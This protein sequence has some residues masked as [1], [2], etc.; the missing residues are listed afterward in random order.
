MFVPTCGASGF[1]Y[2]VFN[3]WEMEQFLVECHQLYLFSGFMLGGFWKFLKSKHQVPQ[4]APSITQVVLESSPGHRPNF[5]LLTKGVCGAQGRD[6]VSLPMPC[7]LLNQ[8]LVLVKFVILVI[9]IKG[10]WVCFVDGYGLWMKTPYLMNPLLILWSSWSYLF[11]SFLFFFFSSFV[12]FSL[13]LFFFFF[14]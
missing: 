14:R 3:S 7:N 4:M 6:K 10:E 2:R 12:T 11:L 1:S 8:R 13:F 5:S 9:P